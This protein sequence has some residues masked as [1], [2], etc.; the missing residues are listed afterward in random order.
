MFRLEVMSPKFR[1]AVTIAVLLGL[2]GALMVSTL[3]GI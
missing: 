2:I 1:R 3:A